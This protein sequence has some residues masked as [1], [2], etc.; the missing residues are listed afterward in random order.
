MPPPSTELGGYISGVPLG[1]VDSLH[2]ENGTG[3][4]DVD[5][6]ASGHKEAEPLGRDLDCRRQR[7]ANHLLDAG[8]LEPEWSVKG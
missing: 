7:S 8:D 3:R 5:V 6:R 2:R 1:A 4:F